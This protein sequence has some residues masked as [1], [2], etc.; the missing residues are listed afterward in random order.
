MQEHRDL[1]PSLPIEAVQALLDDFA[2]RSAMEDTQALDI[3]TSSQEGK[4]ATSSLR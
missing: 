3:S 4:S 1:V 2:R